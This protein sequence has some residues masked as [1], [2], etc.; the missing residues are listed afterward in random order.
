MKS[1]YI[2]LFSFWLFSS[3]NIAYAIPITHI[4]AAKNATMGPPDTSKIAGPTGIPQKLQPSNPPTQ[5]DV[6][7]S[8]STWGTDVCSPI[9]SLFSTLQI[10]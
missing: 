2:K 7:D 10:F 4:R 5:S 8:I 6:M 1:F 9:P 3:I